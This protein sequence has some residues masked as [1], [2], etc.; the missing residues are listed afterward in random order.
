MEA[1]MSEEIAE[2][3]KQAWTAATSG[4]S[5]IDLRRRDPLS[6]SVWLWLCAMIHSSTN[7]QLSRLLPVDFSVSQLEF[8]V[9]GAVGCGGGTSFHA[10]FAEF[11][12]PDVDSIP[13]NIH[14]EPVIAITDPAGYPPLLSKY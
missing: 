4:G 11:F 3:S 12:V 14:Q 8:A 1:V 13:R 7:Y 6:I 5:R 9:A 10:S 2:E